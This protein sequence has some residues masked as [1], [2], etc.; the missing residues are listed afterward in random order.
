MADKGCSFGLG[1]ERKKL[2]NL[3]LKKRIVLRSGKAETLTPGLIISIKT[4]LQE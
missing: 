3:H 1:D 2:T 4:D